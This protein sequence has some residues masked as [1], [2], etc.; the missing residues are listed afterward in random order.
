M[1]S[2]DAKTSEPTSRE[3]TALSSAGLNRVAYRP[4]RRF[5]ARS[6]AII[7]KP[8]TNSNSP[9][10]CAAL[11]SQSSGTAAPSAVGGIGSSGLRSRFAPGG[12][13]SYA[14]PCRTKG[15]DLLGS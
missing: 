1:S 7:G 5:A 12:L 11:H 3:R 9:T 10:I 13:N 15:T 6:N 14:N 4:L 8:T 2:V